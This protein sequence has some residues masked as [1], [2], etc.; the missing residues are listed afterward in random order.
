MCGI[1]GF[2]DKTKKSGHVELSDMTRALAHRGP[3]GKGLAIFSELAA[4]VGFGHR[5]LSII[6][7]HDSASQPMCFGDWS[8]VF[9]GEIY[10]YLEIR[11]TLEALGRVFSTKSDTEVILQAFDEWNLSAVDRFIGMFAFAIINSKKEKLWFFRDRPGV[12]PFYYYTDGQL[13]LFASELK[14]FHE[15][16]GFKKKID[17][18]G[19][20]Q[21]MQF[22]Y[23]KAPITI[24][25]HTFKLKPGHYIEFDINS[26]Q[27]Q[28]MPYWRA[29]DY[30]NQPKMNIGDEE[31]ISET[32]KLMLSAVEYRMVAD[33]PVGV[34]LSG[35]YDSS[36][37]T[38]LLQH[39][40]T[41]KLKTFSIGFHETGFDE[42]PFAK[43]V[44]SYLGT[45]HTEYY[46]TA[47]DAKNLIPEIADHW[48]EPFADASSIPTMLVSKLARQKV[49]VA[50]S[51][52]AGDE[53]F[54]GYSKYTYILSGIKRNS[55]VPKLL[56]NAAAGVLSQ[57]N[58]GAIPY[59]NK[60]YNFQT[61]YYKGIELLKSENAISGLSSIAKIFTDSEVHNLLNV[62]ELVF[63]ADNTELINC[64]YADDISQ[65]LYT[66]YQTYMV[67]D[68]LTKVDRATMS[69][70]LEG[71][72]PLLDHRLLEWSARL[73][74]HLKIRNGEKKYILKEICHKHIP[75]S[76]MARPKMGFGIPI[77]TWFDEEIGIYVS[78]YLSH[79]YIQAQGIFNMHTVNEIVER[80]RSNK[81]ENVFKMWNLVMF[82]LWYERWMK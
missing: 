34:F 43:K 32:E 48:D 54:G 70:S 30:Y 3:D 79:S 47:V 44:A 39:N 8:I 2:I 26:F 73:P 46:C 66:D 64:Q 56:R 67:D 71:R 60:T 72:E 28:E 29:L 41:Q 81:K 6:D 58:P 19:A 40:R 9:N 4:T 57:I 17:S 77:V 74:S 50:L 7:L 42:A 62:K 51:A 18:R 38:A 15:H 35:G 82:Q 22:G 53:L 31:A 65:L 78:Q 45:D 69:V 33:V 14:A 16:P 21:F 11:S 23:I 13:L 80:Y 5:R 36:T 12:K 10:N 61:R 25:Q 24:F 68:I 20:A 52:D 75:K 37:V 55:L 76:I 27:Y 1:A 63:A 49:T 59:F